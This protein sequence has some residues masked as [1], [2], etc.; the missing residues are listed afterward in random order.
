[1]R[2]LHLHLHLHLD[3]DT[4][5]GGQNIPNY[6][7][8]HLVPAATDA[9]SDHTRSPVAPVNLPRH[10]KQREGRTHREGGGKRAWEYRRRPYRRG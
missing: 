3:S 6:P 5:R 8:I 10:I 4:H 7:A 1:M 9:A 2:D